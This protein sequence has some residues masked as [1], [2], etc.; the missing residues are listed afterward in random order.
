ME[1]VT[2]EQRLGNERMSHVDLVGENFPCR[3]EKVERP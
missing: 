3:G 2:F 1:E